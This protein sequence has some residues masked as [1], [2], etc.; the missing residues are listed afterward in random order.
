MLASEWQ[1]RAL[2]RAQLL[3]AGFAVVATDTWSGMRKLLR[4]RLRP[5][6]ALVDLKGLREPRRVLDHL[7]VLMK[8]D[9]VLVLAAT[10]T[11]PAPDLERGGFRTLS[12]PI[13]I[14]QVVRAARDAMRSATDA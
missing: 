10:G 7:S 2:I 6:L 9:R 11:I 8:A 3:E 13:D 5:R 12:R 14:E 4:P 1:P